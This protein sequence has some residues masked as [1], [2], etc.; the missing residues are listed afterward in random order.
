MKTEQ[1]LSANILDIIF[2]NRNK[3]YGAYDLRKTYKNRLGKALGVT[4]LAAGAVVFSFLFI[5]KENVTMAQIPDIRVVDIFE[6]APKPV[7]PEIPK[8]KPTQSK[9]ANK[10]PSQLY[11][12]NVVITKIESQA[13][14]LAKNL[15]SVFISDRTIE[16]IPG[17][18]PL[19]QD[20]APV[21][22]TNVPVIPS[23]AVDKETAR[24]SA[25]IMPAFPGGLEALRKYLQRNLQTPE[26]MEQ[27]VVISVKIKFVVGY[28][29][30]LKAF[31]T[32]EDGGATYNNEVMRVLKRMPKWIPGKSN[33]ENVSVYYTIPVKFTAAE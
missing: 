18:K 2:D 6:E 31:E 33:G 29:G 32:I 3:N 30:K 20:L 7:E 25:E 19:V 9:A 24:M 13:D 26:E 21:S 4:F 1:I 28:D 12:K 5:K 11:V 15:D 14:Q 16:G 22:V 8:P 10:A 27:G 17:Y 23:T